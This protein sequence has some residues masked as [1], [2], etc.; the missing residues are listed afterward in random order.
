LAVDGNPLAEDDESMEGYSP[1][2]TIVKDAVAD[3]IEA[4][5]EALVS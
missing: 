1:D 3:M 5:V 4:A 2:R